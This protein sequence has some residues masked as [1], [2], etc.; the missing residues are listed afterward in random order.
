MLETLILSLVSHLNGEAHPP[1]G[2]ERRGVRVVEVA[3]VFYSRREHLPLVHVALA[4]GAAADAAAAEEEARKV[5][6]VRRIGRE[7]LP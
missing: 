1:A 3:A 4:R 2:A 7:R 5:A 6:L